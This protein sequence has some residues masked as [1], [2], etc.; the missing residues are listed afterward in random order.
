M[1]MKIFAYYLKVNPTYA[2]QDMVAHSGRKHKGPEHSQKSRFA[3]S[4]P[5][6]LLAHV[7]SAVASRPLLYAAP[8]SSCRK[9][10]ESRI[11]TTRYLHI[12]SRHTR[13]DRGPRFLGFELDYI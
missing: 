3:L 2:G 12:I 7:F 13:V 4:Q 10:S 9:G 8:H 5:T 11:Y 1:V 6:A